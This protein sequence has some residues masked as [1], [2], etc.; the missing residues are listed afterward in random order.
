MSPPRLGLRL[1]LLLAFLVVV[2]AAL[3]TVGVAVLLVGP[4]YFAEAMGH[5]PDDPMGAAMDEATRAAFGEAMRQALLAAT[6]IAVVAATIVS[7]AVAGRI[8][9]P[10]TAL[11]AAARR[12]ARGHYAERV[13][14]EEGDEIGVLADSFNE[15]AASLETTERRRVQLVGDVA[16]ELRT[17]L[18]T[19]DG[20]LEGLEDGVVAPEPETWTLL[21]GET[22]RLTRL[23]DDLSELWRAEAHQVPLRIEAVDVVVVARDVVGPLR[24]RWP[25]SAGWMSRAPRAASSRARTATDSPRSSPTTWPT[26]SGTRPTAP[27]SRS[28]RH[29]TATAS[30]CRSSDE[31][32]GLAADQLDAV[33]ERFYRVDAARTRE[34]GGAGIGLAIVRA[35]AEAMEGRAWAT[36]DGPRPGEHLQRGAA[37]RLSH[38]PQ[39]AALRGVADGAVGPPESRTREGGTGGRGGTG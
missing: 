16:H 34:A 14:V 22:A 38:P 18:A 29:A 10:I 30:A 25:V 33:F 1:R 31:G 15:M 2:A 8:V 27:P 28:R 32:P 12:I 23:V 35:L 20:Y 9:R 11:A 4:G 39:H 24:A 26:P 36:S 6:L 21:R 17:P 3:G 37:G 7:L 13:P 5:R 19:L